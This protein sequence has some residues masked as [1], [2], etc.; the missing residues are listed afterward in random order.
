ML[1]TDRAS[2]ENFGCRREMAPPRVT[3]SA[4]AASTSTWLS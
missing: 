3:W 2:N 4:Y 1:A